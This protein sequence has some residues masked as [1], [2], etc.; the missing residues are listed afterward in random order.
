MVKNYKTLLFVF[1]VLLTAGYAAFFIFKDFT[2]ANA[3]LAGF[4][5]I[6]IDLFFLSRHLPSAVKNSSVGGFVVQSM[7]RWAFI[8][9]CIYFALVVL[10]LYKWSFVV[11]IILPFMGV[12]ITIIYQIF[13]GKEDGTSS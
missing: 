1:L 11:G 6:F 7:V 12:F 8:G 5:I 9:F 4:V 3:F 2:F 10:N 13:R